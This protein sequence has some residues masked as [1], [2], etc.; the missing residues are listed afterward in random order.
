[1][2]DSSKYLKEPIWLITILAGL[3]TSKWLSLLK[4]DLLSKHMSLNL[5]LFDNRG[6]TFRK[7]VSVEALSIPL[8][9][10]D[11]SALYYLLS[12]AFYF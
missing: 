5:A 6:L 4:L 2:K 1:M 8:W 3:N 12:F 7:V 11:S 9:I 10:L